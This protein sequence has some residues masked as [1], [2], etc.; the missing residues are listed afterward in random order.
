MSDAAPYPSVPAPHAVFAAAPVRARE[1]IMPTRTDGP[2]P[3]ERAAAAARRVAPQIGCDR[4]SSRDLCIPP[5]LRNVQTAGLV[6]VFGNSRKV[7]RGDAIYR[8]GN[9]FENLYVLRAGSSKTIALHRDGREQITGFQV[10]GEF[11]GM[12]GLTTGTHTLDAIALED[13]QV[14]AIP[15]HALETMSYSDRELQRHLNCLM[16]REIVRESAHLM[17]MGSMNADE[18]VAAF[19][20]HLSQRYRERGY[21]P[22]EFQLRMTREEIGCYL[23]LK[24][25]TVSR[26]LT[27]LQRRGLI[28]MNGKK[29][30]IVDLDQ[31]ERV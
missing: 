1:A 14:C 6:G 10:C 13:S 15:Y 24:L 23:G 28:Q 19:L 3:G 18:R 11:I 21:S 31:L 16:S 25:E 12:E 4:C 22:T 17:L 9:A 29:A 7:K 26:M 20:V 27:R 30:R 8:A 2:T 5:S